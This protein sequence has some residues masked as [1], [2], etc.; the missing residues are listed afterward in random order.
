[1]LCPGTRLPDAAAGSARLVTQAASAQP[2]AWRRLCRLEC[3]LLLIP[4]YRRTAW[5]LGAHWSDHHSDETS[6]CS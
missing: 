6:N 1:M 2:R 4:I 5:Y 3:F